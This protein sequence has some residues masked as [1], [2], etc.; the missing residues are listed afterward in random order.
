MIKRR[1]FPKIFPGWWIVL[2]SGLLS[3]WGMGYYMYGISALFKPIASEL[4]FTR[5]VTSVPAAIA[6]LLRVLE[7]PL[8]GWLTDKY[9]PRW[10]V[11]IGGFFIGLGLVGMSYINS[12]WSYYIAWGIV[13]GTGMNIAMNVPMDTAIANWFVKKRGRAQG[14]KMALTGL[15]G[16]LV[17]P[18]IAWLITSV[19]WRQTCLIGGIVMW[20]GGLPLAWFFLKRHRPEYYGLLPDGAT[21][22]EAVDSNRM[23]DKGV[24]YAAEVDEVEFTLRQAM[25]TSAFWLLITA[26]AVHGL[27]W[28]A[29]QLHTIPFLTDIGID[30]LAAAAMAVI[31]VSVGLPFRFIGGIL[32]DRLKRQHLRFLMAGSYFLQAI[33]IIIFLL[34][35]TIAMIY[36]WFVLLGIGWGSGITSYSVIGGRYFGR[37]AFGSIRGTGMAIMAPVS[38]VSAIGAGWIYDTTGSYIS[39]F[40]ISAAALT[41]ATIIMSMAKPPEPPA[42]ITD[43]HSIT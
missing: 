14:I 27:A 40:V 7:S 15:S 36:V 35:Q 42:Q 19:G 2:S 33:G 11:L 31:Y 28:V 1:R 12:L 39:A 29:F 3:L 8:S 10:I 5:A 17:L 9:G 16:V 22:E 24:E 43:I 38:I 13:V 32:A 4:G 18:L 26:Q 20:V 6:N 34:N 41:A 25:K 23:I 37:K 30:P 21:T